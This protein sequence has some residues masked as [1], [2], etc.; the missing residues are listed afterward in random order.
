MQFVCLLLLGL[1]RDVAMHENVIGVTAAPTLAF[2]F[3]VRLRVGLLV[4]SRVCLTSCAIPRTEV[5]A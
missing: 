1:R 5:A 4:R 2:G 3:Q